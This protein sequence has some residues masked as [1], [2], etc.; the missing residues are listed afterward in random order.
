MA[1]DSIGAFSPDFE[2]YCSQ[3][4][5]GGGVIDAAH[6]QLSIPA[7][8]TVEILKKSGIQTIGGP[9]ES[10]LLTPTGAALLVKLNPICRNYTPAMEI[11]EISYGCGQKE[12]KNFPNT[13][14]ILI[15][16]SEIEREKNKSHQLER[17]SQNITVLSTNVDDIQGEI[18]GNF[19]SNY[20]Q[21]K[22]LDIQVN[23]STTKKNR[24]SYK[25][26]V[27]CKPK[28]QFEII[29]WIITELGT[30]GV[31]Y[32]VVKRVCVEREIKKMKF[33]WKNQKFL[34]QCKISYFGE[35]KNRKIVNVKPEFDDLREISQKTN[36][37]IR[38][39]RNKIMEQ[40]SRRYF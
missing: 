34:V 31:R 14:R 17:Y 32:N 30:L 18:I 25:I 12:F 35:G 33:S 9:I 13:T 36:E 40:I 20:P 7:P 28:Y 27:L 39:L 11:T 8:A 37:P 22:I 2:I 23:P 1:L 26:Q 16:K 21:E 4:P 24:T 3:I 6:G 5:L 38:K 10:E 15:G 19:L 29:E